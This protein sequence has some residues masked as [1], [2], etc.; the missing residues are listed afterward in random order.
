MCSCCALG[1]EEDFEADDE[2]PMEDGVDEGNE[3]SPSLSR[4]E[5][6]KRRNENG[7]DNLNR[8]SQCIFF[9]IYL[10]KYNSFKNFTLR[11]S[12]EFCSPVLFTLN[13]F[14]IRSE[15]IIVSLLWSDQQ[16]V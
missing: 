3:T 11:F 1:Y 7:S 13:F 8:N 15:R 6:D 16:L 12:I 14:S 4:K 2:G 5:E 10:M 9:Y